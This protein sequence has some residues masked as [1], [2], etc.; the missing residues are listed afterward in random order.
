MNRLS[1]K[2]RAR[3]LSVLCEGMGVNAACRITGAS[4]NTVLKLLA[5]VGEACALYQDRVMRGLQ[6]KRIEC[7]EVSWLLMTKNRTLSSGRT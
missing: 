4:K 7:D 3:I 1:T 6:C 5:E 2:D